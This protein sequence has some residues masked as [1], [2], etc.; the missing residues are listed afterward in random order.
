MRQYQQHHA[1]DDERHAD[2]FARGRLLTECEARDELREQD[3]D[4]SER[5]RG[6]LAA[7]VSAKARNQNCGGDRTGK[8]GEQRRLPGAQ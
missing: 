4:Q 6:T 1:A 7:V 8:A 3:L 2:G 5:V